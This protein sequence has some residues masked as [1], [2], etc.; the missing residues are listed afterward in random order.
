MSCTRFQIG[1]VEGVSACC[2]CSVP[3]VARSGVGEPTTEE[4]L[5]ACNFAI[6]ARE[7][8]GKGL[9]GTHWVAV[10][11]GENVV[12]YSTKLHHN[13]VHCEKRKDELKKCSSYCLVAFLML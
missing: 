3:I 13:V 2:L 8:Y 10:V 1:L 11:Q 5:L 6:K 7:R 12:G 4:L 9:H